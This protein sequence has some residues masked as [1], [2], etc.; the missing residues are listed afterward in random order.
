FAFSTYLGGASGEFVG[1]IATDHVGNVY[2]VGSTSSPDFPV[3][4]PIQ[5]SYG[6]SGDA[7]VAKINASGSA[8]IYSS[9]LGG[10]NNET[11]WAIAVDVHGA[12]YVTG[13]TSSGDFPVANAVQPTHAAFADAFVAQIVEQPSCPEN[14]T[15]RVGIWTSPFYPIP[16]TQFGVQW[17]LVW[18]PT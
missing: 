5:P 8:L 15:T 17:A 3:V 2:V 14:V 16:G 4:D 6:L 13:T 18:N 12:A 1:G 11:G 9:F 7:F 10:S